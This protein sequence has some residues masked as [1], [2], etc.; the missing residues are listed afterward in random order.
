[1]NRTVSISLPGN[2]LQLIDEVKEKRRDPTRS[3]T[4]RVLLLKALADMS[5]LSKDEKKALGII[6]R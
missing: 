2:L 4:I 6:E 5:F 1:L 3:D